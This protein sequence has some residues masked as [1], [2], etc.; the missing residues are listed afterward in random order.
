MPA[1]VFQVHYDTNTYTRDTRTVTVWFQNRRQLAKKQSFIVNKAPQPMSR[2]PLGTISHRNQ[3]SRQPSYSSLSQYSSGIDRNTPQ[4]YAFSRQMKRELWE[5]LPSTPPSQPMS[6]FTSAMPSPLAKKFPGSHV[7]NDD[8]DKENIGRKRK[9]ILEWAC[10]RMAKRQRLQP[11]EE[12]LDICGDETEEEEEEHEDTLV[13]FDGNLVNAKLGKKPAGSKQVDETGIT[14]TGS[15]EA[16]VIPPEYSAKFDAD[17]VF[18]A[19]LL[20]TFQYAYRA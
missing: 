14:S 15:L 1:S 8:S 9:P 19:S 4:P 6:A 13:D 16:I 2:Q 11:V 3:P 20:L 18:G 17:V 7:E 10:A 5:H 12:D